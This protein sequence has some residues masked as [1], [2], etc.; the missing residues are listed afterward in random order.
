MLQPRLLLRFSLV[1][2]VVG[3]VLLYPWSFVDR[4]Y[5]RFFCGWNNALFSRFWFWSDGHAVFIDLRDTD[6]FEQVD[7]ATPGDLPRGVK[8]LARS[9]S[10]DTLVLVMNRSVPSTFGQRR[11]SSRLS[12]YW[13]TAGLVALLVATPI[14]WA[15][16]G[17]SLLAGLLVLH[18]FLALRMSV[19]LLVGGLADPAKKYALF[20]PGEY[21]F[22]MLKRMDEVLV[23]NPAVPFLMAAA[24]WLFVVFLGSSTALFGRQDEEEP[25]QKGDRA[26]GGQGKV[27]G[28]G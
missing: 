26:A 2:V 16:R 1:L 7:A 11:V 4:G 19:E 22:G 17:W 12:G 8:L 28:H 15:R 21:W 24:I 3:T 13:P 18:A 25:Q 27:Q 6:I 14:P 10:L 20:H 9:A 5:A 23:Q